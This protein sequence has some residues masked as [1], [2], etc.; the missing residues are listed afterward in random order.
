ML[1]KIVEIKQR[2]QGKLTEC[3]PISAE[4]GPEPLHCVLQ[5]TSDAA[6]CRP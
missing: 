1:Y 2:P 3:P 5:G 4:S 6:I